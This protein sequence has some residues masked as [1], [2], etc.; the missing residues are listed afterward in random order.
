MANASK[1]RQLKVLIRRKLTSQ[2]MCGKSASNSLCVPTKQWMV[3][4]P[5]S[6]YCCMAR[7]KTRV[8]GITISTPCVILFTFLN[9]CA[10]LC[11]NSIPDSAFHSVM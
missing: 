6:F 11:F 7:W 2:K 5:F 4:S 10:S 3:R 9:R 1:R 8:T